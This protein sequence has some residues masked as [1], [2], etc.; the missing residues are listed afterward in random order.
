MIKV[1]ISSPYENGDIAVNVHRQIEAADR[2][3]N[4][5]YVPFTP[6]LFHFHHL[7]FQRIRQDWLD[8]DMVWLEQ[9]DCLLR[10]K[11]PQESKGAD[12]ECKRAK[13]LGLP[14]FKTVEQ[15][16]KFYCESQLQKDDMLQT[17]GIED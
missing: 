15:V 16:E 11:A 17:L 14:I 5:G 13:E 8:L 12:L 2:L 7:V 4:L 3:M 1:F 9:C 6:A 10:L